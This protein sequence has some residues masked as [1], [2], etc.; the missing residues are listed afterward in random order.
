MMV[1]SLL[2]AGAATPPDVLYLVGE[3]NGWQ[4]PDTEAGRGYQLTDEDKDGIYTGSFEIPEQACVFKIFTRQSTWENSDS[5]LGI[6]DGLYDWYLFKGDADTLPIGT[7]PVGY[8]T[9]IKITNWTG[10]TLNLSVKL[11]E[12]DG[13][14]ESGTVTLSSDTQPEFPKTPA[15]T[16][17][18]G[19][20]NDYQIPEGSNL[21]GA[22]PMTRYTNDDTLPAYEGRATIPAGQ[23]SI[24]ICYVDP[25]SGK[26][27]YACPLGVSASLYSQE[28]GQPA[29]SSFKTVSSESFNKETDHL[30]ITNWTGGVLI[31]QFGLI[32]NIMQL[33]WDGAPLNDFPTEALYMILETN[34][35]KDIMPVNLNYYTFFEEIMKIKSIIFTT[36]NSTEPD[37]STIWGVAEGINNSISESSQLELAKGGK[38]IIIDY[39][40]LIGGYV[41]VNTYGRYAMISLDKYPDYNEIPEI[42]LVGYMTDWK[43]PSAKNEEFYQA[44]RLENVGKGNFKGTFFCP[45]PTE[46][47]K[48]YFRFYKALTGWDNQDSM[49]A[50]WYDGETTPVILETN[51]WCNSYYF[52]GGKGN[53]AL[54][55]WTEDKYVEFNVNM[56]N[57][58][59]SMIIS[60]S[61]V[62]SVAADCDSEA[63]YFTLQGVRVAEPAG[64]IYI[65]VTSKGSEKVYIR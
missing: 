31:V 2:T 51:N 12:T 57:K 11:T 62:E 49:G 5:Y 8:G 27:V 63:V 61:G 1:A 38:P 35:G 20:F 32:E 53:W 28:E 48:A 6:Q 42:Y 34:D 43:E 60:S 39:D 3:M 58:M 7:W 56:I 19:A 4:T 52:L 18:I 9:N 13:K 64:G 33:Q 24:A 65:K 23:A 44:Y 45:C 25:V 10:G 46:P 55:N 21:N 26:T 29:V 15:T 47:D 59:V 14:Y 37:P 30:T 54:Q 17:V 41:Y 36:E 40:G 16:Y 22:I 50:S